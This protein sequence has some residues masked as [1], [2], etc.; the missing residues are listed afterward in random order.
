MD[1]TLN[2]FVHALRAAEI[3]VSP[4]ET[5][6]A[7][8]VVRQVGVRDAGLLRNALA[9]ALAKT[10]QEKARFDDGFERFFAQLAFEEPARRSLLGRV[11]AGQVIDAVGDALGERPRALIEGVLDGRPAELAWRVQQA[12]QGLDL[13]AMRALRD[14][15]RHVEALSR[16]LGLDELNV[17]IARR[18]GGDSD[19]DAALR[20]LRQYAEAQVREYVD[21]QYALRVDATGKRAVLDAALSG[22][23]DQLPPD[24]YRE[25]D[26]VVH[27]LAERLAR[28]HRRRRRRAERGHLDLKRTL[29]RNVAYDGSLFDLHWRSQRRRR[30]SVFVVCDLS[31]SV[32]RVARFLLMFL[33]DLTDVLP[34]LRTFGF[35]NRLGE[36]TELF[37]RHG[38]ER[39][40][41]EALFVWGKGTTDYG[42]ALAD[43]R[44]LAGRDLDRH[45]TVIF[46]G[47]ARGNYFP[48]RADLLRGIAERARR[49]YWLNPEPPERW[50]EGDSLMRHYAPHCLRVDR[51]ARLAD[52]E[53]FADRLVSA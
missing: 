50:G 22:Q 41:A 37:A 5:L 28:N 42:Q 10:P 49:V 47:D 31:S 44:A 12:A 20:Y 34:G 4:A 21:R 16:A 6:D 36:I 9:L 2:R 26:R 15:R 23:L 52:I 43:L 3:P 1:L 8:E 29:R 33:Y 17:L 11:S 39:A 27:K 7:F 25:V 51:C 19:V 14:K 48:H 35:S 13:D 53:R 18:A 32:G 40:V 46:L 38:A 24:Y 30:S 45:A